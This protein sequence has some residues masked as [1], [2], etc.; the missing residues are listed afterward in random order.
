MEQKQLDDLED[1][2]FGEEFIEDLEDLP[3][4]KSE[5]V[6]ISP[7]EEPELRLKKA[8]RKVNFPKKSAVAIKQ[9]EKKSFIVKDKSSETEK[10]V[11]IEKVDLKEDK[12]RHF[13]KELRKESA[14]AET[15]PFKEQ[16]KESKPV[17]ET[18]SPVNPW[19]EEKKGSSIFGETSTWKALTGVAIVLLILSLFTQGFNFSEKNVLSG[20]AVLTL[21]EAERKALTYVNTQLLEAPFQAELESSQEL[22]SLYKVSLT[23]AGQ[24]VDSYVT[25]DGRLFFPQGFEMDDLV[26]QKQVPQKD[27]PDLSADNKP[28]VSEPVLENSEETVQPEETEMEVKDPSEE[29]SQEANEVMKFNLNAK[30]WI[31]QPNVLRV[32]KGSKVVITVVPTELDFTFAVPSLGVEKKII[33]TTEVEFTANKAGTFDFVCGSCEDWR[34]MRGNLV[35]E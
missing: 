24:T 30:K 14:S 13:E 23:V 25:K 17:V 27:D 9:T 11:S 34:G 18:S 15:K 2:F 28:A 16:F 10:M 26:P 12:E 22:D 5:E 31:F 1:S 32:K 35:I 7:R 6:K 3:P 4:V 20:A 19:E 33:G 8:N 29:P 21:P